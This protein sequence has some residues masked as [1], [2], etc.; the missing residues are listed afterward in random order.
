MWYLLAAA[1]A[2]GLLAGMVFYAR[3]DAKR[4][5]RLAALKREAEERANAQSI[6]D[7]V[8]RMSIDSVRDRLQQTK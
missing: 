2:G 6:T 5:E 1:I 8:R 7:N 4:A 3:Q